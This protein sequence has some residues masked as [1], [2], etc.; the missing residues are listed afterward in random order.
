MRPFYR[1]LSVGDRWTNLVVHVTTE[2]GIVV[3]EISRL[4]ISIWFLFHTELMLYSY[5][6]N[7]RLEFASVSEI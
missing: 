4:E 3:Q 5:K 2:G 7:C 6:L 1:K